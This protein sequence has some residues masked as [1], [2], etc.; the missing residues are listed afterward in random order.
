MFSAGYLGGERDSENALVCCMSNG[1]SKCSVEMVSS[2]FLVQT[3]V[4][5]HSVL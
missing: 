4:T 3:F 5:E 2:V 1:F